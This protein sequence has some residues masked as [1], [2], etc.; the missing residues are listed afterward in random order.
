LDGGNKF[1]LV[2]A[3]FGNHLEERGGRM[4]SKD[5]PKYILQVII[6]GI[7]NLNELDT[8]AGKLH[9]LAIKNWIVKLRMLGIQ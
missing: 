6:G 4:L 7:S 1:V 8:Y 5:I 3:S 2:K 9:L